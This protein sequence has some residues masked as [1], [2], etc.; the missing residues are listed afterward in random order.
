MGDFEPTR[1]GNLR[2]PGQYSAAVPT[3]PP[4]F[5]WV[6]PE[7]LVGF[8]VE[9]LREGV[10][11]A[12][13]N[14]DMQV[15]VDNST[16]PTVTDVFKGADSVYVDLDEDGDYLAVAEFTGIDM[17][18]VAYTVNN[19]GTR[20]QPF[21]GP[22]T[23]ED[24]ALTWLTDNYDRIDEF[25]GEQ[26]LEM[27]GDVWGSE[28]LVAGAPIAADSDQPVNFQAAGRALEGLRLAPHFRGEGDRAAGIAADLAAFIA[29]PPKPALGSYDWDK[30]TLTY[31]KRLNP[32]DDDAANY[33]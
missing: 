9:D 27:A 30:T 2:S 33:L 4:A 3:P 21:L 29:R 7:L 8:L 6:T 22:N 16:S 32:M 18:E 26:G 11:G 28:K 24:Q 31:R 12:Q 20:R 14:P 5:D 10:Q 23:T 17:V 1:G 25:W 15:Y 19:L 13:L